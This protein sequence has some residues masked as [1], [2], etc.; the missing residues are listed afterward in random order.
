[1]S[2]ARL[3][4][5][6]ALTWPSS[7]FRKMVLATTQLTRTTEDLEILRSV[8]HVQGAAWS[9]HMAASLETRWRKIHADW[10]AYAATVGMGEQYIRGTDVDTTMERIPKMFQAIMDTIHHFPRIERHGLLKRLIAVL[11][12]MLETIV[13]YTHDVRGRSA[14]QPAYAGG[15]TQFE[16]V[17]YLRFARAK[18]IYLPCLEV[19]R[20]LGSKG[21]A[22]FF[23]Q[24]EARWKAL[25]QALCTFHEEL[26]SFPGESEGF[27]EGLRQMLEGLGGE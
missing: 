11:I 10:Y 8:H 5:Q 17:L 9:G 26:G 23:R 25:Y 22:E 13:R 14:T 18:E 19:I 16:Y 3:P 7:S 1:M 2:C 6:V 24:D 21:H 4:L 15:S 27:V 20:F 12:E